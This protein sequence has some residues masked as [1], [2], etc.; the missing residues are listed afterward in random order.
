MNFD[1]GMRRVEDN[2]LLRGQ[3]EFAD[4]LGADS[5]GLHIAFARSVSAAGWIG[6]VQADAARDMP[7]VACVL[8]GEDWVA[9]G[10]GMLESRLN[11]PG[12]DD[13]KMRRPPHPPIATDCVRAIGEIVAVVFA[14][15]RAQA[16]D[17]AELIEWD[18]DETEAVTDLARAMHPDAPR[19]WPEYPDNLCFRLHKG[20]A[21]ATRAALADAAHVV[22]HTLPISRVTAAALE[23]RALRADFDAA[24]GVYTLDLGSQAP[25]RI[26]SDL[27][28]TLGLQPK[29]IRVISRACG[30][31]FGMKNFGYPEYALA[32]W[33]ARKTGHTLRW[34]A[35]RVE[36]FNSDSHGRDQLVDAALA[37]DSDGHFLGLDVTIRA[38]LGARLGPSTVHPPVANI[39]GLVGVY[40]TPVAHVTVEGYF[41]NTQQTAPYRGAGRPEA[42]YVI[43][44]LI[45]LA[46]AE[47]GIDRAELRRRNMITVDQFP[48]QTPLAFN[49][50]SGDFVAI[51][52]Q[53]LDAADWA[54]FPARR[55]AARKRGRLRGIGI[56]NPIEI[57]GGPATG[58]NP[59][60]AAIEL[61]PQG[62]V[63]LRVGSC[64]AGQG[65][66][67]SFRMLVAQRLGLEP[68]EISILTGD[69][70]LVARGIG[71]FGSRTLAAAGTSIFAGLDE[72]IAIL[73]Q[74]AADQL[75]VAPD[76]L[77]LI[78]GEFR[79]M[80]TDLT[81]ALRKV[82]AQRDST[83][84]TEHYQ[85][86]DGPTYPN[87]CHVCEVEIDSQTGVVTLLR[88]VV[89]DDVGTVLN[90]IIVKG[91]IVG[92][93]VQGAGQALGEQ[94][95]YDP[96]SGQLLTASFMDYSMLR[97]MDVPMIEVIS[98]PV[99]TR[100]NPLGVK[101]AGEA[102]TV[103]ALAAV[104]SAVSDALAPLGVRH[105]DMPA[106]PA[107]VWQAIRDTESL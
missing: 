49:Y 97:A 32:L 70:H 98:H 92:G 76:D 21:E 90:P 19:V 63:M 87:G 83:I 42:T 34:T 48:Y 96:D 105:L 2:A 35:S 55:E 59:E 89:V 67:T 84:R 73:K 107:R 64:D 50:D 30:G 15:T 28:A 9:D 82:L 3:A 27:A 69:T 37:I 51:L 53:A 93:V 102:G 78:G 91:Q 57:A 94:I 18:I 26:A 65:H 1:N 6:K 100:K 99:P 31:S 39:G 60:Y 20:D 72:I 40:R 80:G 75:E 22:R 41:T 46:A 11:H 85:A 4:D 24:T 10:M 52:D 7:G 8:T 66:T 14:R 77:E 86:T 17:A 74:D 47:L 13:G 25:H 44:R 43:E 101:G 71:T 56:S 54:G 38:N 79:V 29:D 5:D 58:P 88:Y 45:D 12:P 95:V 16:E 81:V 103:G 33:A 36:S 104:V 23:P 106:T 62:R 68:D 61:T